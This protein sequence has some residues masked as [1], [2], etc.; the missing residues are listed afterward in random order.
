VI[1]RRWNFG[2]SLRNGVAQ[3]LRTGVGLPLAVLDAARFAR[4][5]RID[6]VQ[7]SAAPRTGTLG[8]ALARMSG[9]RLLLHY[10]VIPGRYGGPR[11]AFERAVAR[12]ADG[13]VT[14]SQFL[15]G[16]VAESGVPAGRIDVVVNGVDCNRFSPSVSGRA[17]RQ[18][19]GIGGDEVLVVQL[20]RI[21]QQKRQED[22]VRAFALARREAPRLRLLIVGWEDPRYDGPF[23]SYRAE[24][25]NIAAQAGLGDAM[26]IADPRSDAPQVVAA[27]D[28]VAMPTIEDAWNLAVTEAMAS[29][30]PVIGS[31][32]GGISEQ[33]VDGESGFLVPAKSPDALA[34][35]MVELAADPLLRARMG[36]A[37]RSR[38]LALF[39][40]NRVAEGFAPIYRR[41]VSGRP[42]G[43]E[44]LRPVHP[45]D[46]PTQV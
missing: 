26:I 29:G 42:G 34:R 1:V 37:A 15:A 19:F 28:I 39:D 22:V 18:E 7:C 11:G 31:R 24:L 20:A 30:K 13:Y 46:V 36:A 10:H 38:A 33:I 12:R 16:R 35:R 41:L 3:A 4:R 21:I 17:V 25:E 6:I 40:E 44:S 27:A 43:A 5:E 9:A 23:A 14:V 2:F 45:G 8:L 32:S